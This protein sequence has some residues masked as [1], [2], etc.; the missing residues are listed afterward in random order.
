MV[1]YNNYENVVFPE[2][3]TPAIPIKYTG[4]SEVYILFKIYCIVLFVTE[5]FYS[6]IKKN[7]CNIK[8]FF[9]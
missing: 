5:L 3:G 1:D 4:F 9:F 8:I 7:I 2:P 6:I